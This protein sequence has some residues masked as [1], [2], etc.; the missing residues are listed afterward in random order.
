[1]ARTL[2]WCHRMDKARARADSPHHGMA[3]RRDPAGRSPPRGD[4]G[5]PGGL[6]P[7]Q[8]SAPWCRSGGRVAKDG[9]DPATGRAT[10]RDMARAAFGSYRQLPG[11][12]AGRS[13]SGC[14]WAT[15]LRLRAWRGLA[16]LSFCLAGTGALPGALRP[17]PRASGRIGGGTVGG[18]LSRLGTRASDRDGVR[19]VVGGLR[20]FWR[21]PISSMSRREPGGRFRGRPP[22][23][24]RTGC[25]PCRRA[26][27]VRRPNRGR[28]Y[29]PGCAR[30]VTS[31][32]N[33]LPRRWGDRPLPVQR[34][35]LVDLLS[36][37]TQAVI[38]DKG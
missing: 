18:C 8:G 30:P 5:D 3:R 12:T 15:A 10:G 25:F 1:M 7:R 27:W 34:Q 29:W 37:G 11:R 28:S 16:L 13:R 32:P 35:R 6:Y 17:Q 2:P 9:P 24:G 33:T 22:A 26:C 38:G 31:S 4:G 23:I 14:A 20:G 36:R 21:R 19:P